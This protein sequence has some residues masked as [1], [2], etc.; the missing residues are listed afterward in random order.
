MVSP[1]VPTAPAAVR[2]VDLDHTPN[3]VLPIAT[4]PY[5]SALV[6]VRCRGR[7][8]GT[9]TVTLDGSTVEEDAVAKAIRR[10]LGREIDEALGAPVAP[11]RVAIAEPPATVVVPTC[12]RPAR[13]RRC[14][15][16]L[17]ASDYGPFDVVVVENRP[18]D[19]A[20]ARML[21]RHF[22]GE[23]R[24][25]YVEEPR[26]GSSNARNAG[27]RAASGGIIAFVDDDV[28]VDRD[29]L[30]SAVMPFISA[31][32]VGCVTGLI[33]PLRLDTPQ[34][35]L[36]E[37]FA[38]LGKGFRSVRFAVSDPPSGNP[39]FPY[40]AGRV[41]SGANMVVKAELARRLDGFDPRL[42]GGT[43]ARGGEEL[44]L[45]IR[46][47]QSGAVIVYEPA[48]IVWHD[49]PDGGDELAR[50]AF[51]YGVALTAML[52]KQLL[53]GPERLRLLARVPAGVRYAFDR[54]SP[55]H[56]A[57]AAAF[58]R[59]LDALER[60]GMLVGPAAFVLSAAAQRRATRRA[61]G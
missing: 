30:R 56:A 45:F 29:W 38:A 24:I 53:S 37:Q 4:P 23:R 35:I 20:T 33:L 11:M 58:P 39:L 19:D 15:E 49:H 14:L 6:L 55:K 34:Q 40:T 52:A 59:R 41:G 17:L 43:L 46:I 60:A 18:G 12:R 54:R 25:R 42:G 26:R 8:L 48:A 27:L 5:R 28:V 3:A 44:D 10:Q 32:D 61:G 9:A 57:K 22:A 16:S 7:P 50:H 1:L 13:L 36:L 47:L 21:T 2:V 51:D 31:P